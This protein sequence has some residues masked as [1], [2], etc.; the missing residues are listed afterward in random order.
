MGIQERVEDARCLLQ[1]KRYDG[2]LL[3]LLVAVD[4]TARKENKEIGGNRKRFEKFIEERFST[5]GQ[6]EYRGKLCTIPH[7]FYEWLRCNL[8]HEADLPDDIEFMETDQISIQAGGHPSKT[9]RLSHGWYKLLMKWVETA[10]CNA[11][12]VSGY[13][14]WIPNISE[15]DLRY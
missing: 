1:M 9:L 15:R 3:M 7:V 11:R 14:A 2:A 10:P 5:V 13:S 12:S 4:A 8:V 6:V